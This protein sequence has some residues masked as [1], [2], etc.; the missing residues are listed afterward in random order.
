M[1][2]NIIVVIFLF[3]SLLLTP[4]L[5]ANP[6]GKSIWAR[7]IGLGNAFVA[8]GEDPSTLFINPAGSVG[9]GRSFIS[10]YSRPDGDVGYTSLGGTLPGWWDSSISLG[11][12]NRVISDV[13]IS[14]TETIS[15]ID[16]D[17][18]L[19][20]SKNI[21][22]GLDF[23]L[24]V[25]YLVR[26][27]SVDLPSTKNGASAACDVGLRYQPS[28]WL[29]LGVA[30]QDLGIQFNYSSGASDTYAPNL[31]VGA[32]ALIIGQNGWY[33]H[34][35]QKLFFNLDAGKENNDPL[36][37]H[38]GLEWWPI[39]I[40]AFRLGLDQTT[41]SQTEANN[42]TT[43]GIGVKLAGLTFDYSFYRNES[44][45]LNN[46]HYFS[47]GFV[48]PPPAAAISAETKGFELLHFSDVPPDYWARE[49]IE[50][51]A[52]LGM[53]SGYSDSTFR[54]EQP[55][56]RAEIVT[57][58]VRAK[59]YPLPETK[60]QV[61]SDV[62]LTYPVAEVIQTA[63]ENKLTLG[64]PDRTF[65][66]RRNTSRVEGTVFLTRFDDLELKRGP[67]L[68]SD[69]P[70]TAW[71]LREILAARG[72]GLLTLLVKGDKFY[73]A[74]TLTRAELADLLYRTSYAQEQIRALTPPR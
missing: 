13:P 74:S 54:P 45:L 64:Y 39:D 56:S 67:S 60:K 40:F 52:T 49:A 16:Q 32:S 38:A 55:V 51:T 57:L 48:E 70:N 20:W 34:E 37:A 53:I 4:A 12:R 24:D 50:Y 2:K 46:T 71:A 66:P 11:Y 36:L 72:S 22:T 65:Q 31:A 42:N 21:R 9:L 29:S 58:L 5:G 14:S 15:T 28:P 33:R 69:I 63:Y 17:L 43:Y 62:P 61:F 23:G 6:L 26:S 35:S 44:D 18:L 73:P 25:R 7:P 41:K 30:A 1:K 27:A 19:G 8:F 68:Y 59:D 10:T 47:L 3:F